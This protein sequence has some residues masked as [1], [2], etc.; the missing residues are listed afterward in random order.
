MFR[1][2]AALAVVLGHIRL[3]F[4]ED[5]ATA[6]HSVINAVLYSL[7][8]MGSQAVIVFFVLSGYWVG[9]SVVAKFRSG[10][11]SWADYTGARLTRL[12]LVLLP[13][14]ALTLLLDRVGVALYPESSVYSSPEQ[15]EGLPANL[16]YS[17]STFLGNLAFLQGLHLPIFGSNQ[18]LWSLAFEF[19]YYVLFPCLLALFW[20]GGSLRTRIIGGV[21]SIVSIAVGGPSVLLLFPVW[22]FGAVVAAYRGTL[23]RLLLRIA[24][25]GLAALRA[26]AVVLIV[27][28]S[29][30][31]HEVDLALGLGSIILGAVTAAGIATFVN[32][33]KWRGRADKFLDGASWTAH[34]SYSLYATHMPVVAF[35]AAMFVP[36]FSQRLTMSPLSVVGFLAVL[37]ACCLI[38]YWFSLVTER[39]TEVVRSWLGRLG[40]KQTSDPARGDQAT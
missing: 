12:W 16:S 30:F 25:V 5:Y 22:V 32:D 40:H 39:K 7:T 28:A 2:A 24:P 18:P 13:A 9:G 35:A 26:A 10:T 8:S 3:L 37:S 36:S 27:G 21:L 15:Y 4:F 34:S 19:W 17:P 14:L 20:R 38:A 6:T 1:S 23:S 29:I 33:V 31:A 11:F